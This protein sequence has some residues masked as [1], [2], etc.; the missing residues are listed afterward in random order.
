MTFAFSVSR[1][2]AIPKILPFKLRACDMHTSSKC[3]IYFS[4]SLSACFTCIH[5]LSVLVREKLK[6]R[7]YKDTEHYRSVNIPMKTSKALS[8]GTT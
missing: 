6:T 8:S 3:D 5:D 1:C 7:Y 4:T 2:D